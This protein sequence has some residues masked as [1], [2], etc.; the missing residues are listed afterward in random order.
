M[1][2]YEYNNLDFND[3]YN[4]LFSKRGNNLV[5]FNCFRDDGVFKYSLWNCGDFFVEM[6]YSKAQNK[7][8][9]IEGIAQDDKKVDQY[10]DFVQKHK[11]EDY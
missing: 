9:R 7:V 5:Q 10:I 11:D 2:L 4:F 6:C 1:T 3:R 8:I